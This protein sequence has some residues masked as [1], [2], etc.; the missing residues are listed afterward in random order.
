MTASTHQFTSQAWVQLSVAQELDE[1]FRLACERDLRASVARLK[2][3]LEDDKTV[4]VLLA[5]IQDRIVD[6]YG[7][8]RDVTGTLYADGPKPT[9]LTE[10]ELKEFLKVICE[11]G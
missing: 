4:S 9:L 8:F 2:L 6:E 11:S 5:H 3:Y 1:S 10:A 7:A